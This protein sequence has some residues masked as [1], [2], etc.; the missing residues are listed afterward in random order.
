[1]FFTGDM[2]L[3]ALSVFL[4]VT[5]AISMPHLCAQASSDE[6]WGPFLVE[7]GLHPLGRG[8]P[9]D[10]PIS[11]NPNL[12]SPSQIATGLPFL[13]DLLVSA[14]EPAPHL[15]SDDLLEDTSTPH[16][17]T[18]LRRIFERVLT[19]S[20]ASLHTP[21]AILEELAR[22]T[23]EDSPLF[24][25]IEKARL[26]LLEQSHTAP[27]TDPPSQVQPLFE[28]STFPSLVEKTPPTHKRYTQMRNRPLKERLDNAENHL[29][30]GTPGDL[31]KAYAFFRECYHSHTSTRWYGCFGLA[32]VYLAQNNVEMAR[33]YLNRILK[34]RFA[35]KALL[36]E[37]CTL[38]ETLHPEIMS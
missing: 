8:D 38:L 11:H 1:M 30:R 13:P 20:F 14:P 32:R 2:M 12:L 33:L 17:E 37:A 27:N 24:Q 10:F 16:T 31:S 4:V 5:T 7:G 29:A 26:A 22:Q 21:L 3:R 19:R 23:P 34:S 6:F 18:E 36:Q 25:D 35:N 28:E 9:W 15:C